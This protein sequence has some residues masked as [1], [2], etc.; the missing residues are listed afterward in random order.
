MEFFVKFW[1]IYNQTEGDMIKHPSEVEFYI[2]ST[3]LKVFMVA[4]DSSNRKIIM[5]ENNTVAWFSI[6]PDQGKFFWDKQI[7]TI[8]IQPYEL[9]MPTELSS[10]LTPHLKQASMQKVKSAM[11]Q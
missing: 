3:M 2:I 1:P 9:I 6:M 11:L 8:L 5:G 4:S 10:E 7:L